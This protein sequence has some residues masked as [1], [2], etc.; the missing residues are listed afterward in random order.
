MIQLRLLSGPDAGKTF[1]AKKFPC[2]IGR[3]GQNHLR[4]EEP[5]IFDKHL[6]IDLIPVE[7]FVLSVLPEA[8]ASVNSEAADR[9][10]LRNGDQIEAGSVKIQ[11]LLGQTRQRGGC[12]R[13]PATWIILALICALQIALVYQ[14]S[15]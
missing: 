12:W 11:F 14:L 10:V 7:G 5:G 6:S 13:E 1:L 15:R 8:R 3:S 2:L 9:V 4:L